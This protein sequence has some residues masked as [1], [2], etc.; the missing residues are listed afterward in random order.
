[1]RSAAVVGVA[2]GLCWA[3]PALAGPTEYKAAGSDA[4]AIQPTVDSFAAALGSHRQITWDDVTDALADPNRLPFDRYFGQGIA[5]IQPGFKAFRV[6]SSSDPVFGPQY[7]GH[8]KP[9]SGQRIFAREDLNDFEVNFFVPGTRTPAA[10]NGFGA[11]FT[12]VDKDGPARIDYYGPDW[13]R[14][15]SVT[16]PKANDGLSFAGMK[17]DS[18]QV[19]LVVVHMGEEAFMVHGRPAETTS[20]LVALDD[21]VYGD[22]Q[23]TP[24]YLHFATAAA[25]ATEGG[26]VTVPPGWGGNLTVSYT[27][28]VQPIGGTATPG[29]DYSVNTMPG[30]HPWGDFIGGIDVR[31][32]SDSVREGDETAVLQLVSDDFATI[33][34]PSTVTVTI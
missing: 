15:G 6:S 2:L 22:P 9:Y 34:E 33:D 18:A 4:A 10:V 11:V 20:D 28:H 14:L 21:F 27:T 32:S 12:D 25:E 7:V 8:F 29:A 30:Y 31:T 24:S 19:A 1:M 5:F 17:F 13:T 3:A 26:A 23:A 16:A